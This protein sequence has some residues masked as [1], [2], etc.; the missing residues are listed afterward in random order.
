MQ[1]N[2]PKNWRYGNRNIIL[3]PGFTGTWKYLEDLGNFFNK[4]GF[5]IHTISDIEPNI[6]KIKY[7][8][9]KTKNYILQNKLDGVI[10]IAHSK[11]G[12]ISRYLLNDKE[13][14]NKIKKV[15]N[16]SVPNKGS[17]LGLYSFNNAHELIPWSRIIQDLRNQKEELKKVLN[18]YGVFDNVI[19]P[20]KSLYLEN[21]ENIKTNI[22]G[23][24]KTVKSPKIWR[25]ILEKISK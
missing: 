10:L 24:V 20:N 7:S 11:G 23:H 3:I 5:K 6:Y 8:V 13:I 4:N 9:E 17:I 15:I 16:I 12:I 22:I 2:P 19:I 21:A 1:N 18:I 25:I 14:E